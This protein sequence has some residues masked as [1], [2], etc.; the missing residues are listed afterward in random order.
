VNDIIHTGSGADTIVF[1][2][3]DGQDILY[4]GIGTDNTV[5]LAG[6]IHTT[7][8]SL[9]RQGNDLILE[10]GPS[11]S[12][13]Q[14]GDQINLRNWYD[15]TA[16]YKSVLSLDIVSEAISDFDRKSS[17]KS[18]DRS[19]NQF[20][21]ISVVNAFDQAC[22]TST[23]FQHWDAANSLTAALFAEDSDS[24]L[25]SSAFQPVSVSGLLGISAQAA[26]QN[27]LHAMLLNDQPQLQKQ[28]GM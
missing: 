28:V 5:V 14:A 1:Q 18:G 15:T 25:G 19:I 9:S 13:G 10:V 2:R 22:G 26:N 7:D 6:G 23:T 12:S 20:D 8:I 4:G 11:T 16:N 24:S 21:F 17:Q 27:A 3:G